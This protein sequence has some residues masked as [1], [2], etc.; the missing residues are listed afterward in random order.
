[1]YLLDSS[2]DSW[3]NEVL[4]GIVVAIVLDI[5][6]YVFWAQ[7]AEKSNWKNIAGNNN[8]FM[9]CRFRQY[10]FY[11][12]CWKQQYLLFYQKYTLF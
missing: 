3:E 6:L 2:H 11:H 1:M 5:W 12:N 8:F 7:V 10:L 9:E 4:F